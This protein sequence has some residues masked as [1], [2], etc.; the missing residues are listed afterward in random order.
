MKNAIV[1]ILMSHPL[2]AAAQNYL[3]V[4]Y[5]LLSEH[6]LVLFV[7]VM[8]A[9]ALEVLG[10]LTSQFSAYVVEERGGVHGCVCV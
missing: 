10:I 1:D 7:V 3:F 4:T 5:F 8:F 2:L 9:K 6:P